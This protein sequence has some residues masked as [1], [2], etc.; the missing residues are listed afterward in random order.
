M[1]V[2]GTL[3]AC[4]VTQLTLEIRQRLQ[5]LPP[6]MCTMRAMEARLIRWSIWVLWTAPWVS[7]QERWLWQQRIK[8]LW[9]SLLEILTTYKRYRRRCIRLSLR[10]TSPTWVSRRALLNQLVRKNYLQQWLPSSVKRTYTETVGRNRRTQIID[11]NTQMVQEIHD[12]HSNLR[13]IHPYNSV[14]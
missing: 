7:C 5:I 2:T 10:T 12:Y 9:P 1:E 14:N 11:E 13:A 6:I 4:R 8:R 3:I